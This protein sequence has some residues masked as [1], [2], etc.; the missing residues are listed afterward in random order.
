MSDLE[1]HQDADH[2]LCAY[3]DVYKVLESMPRIDVLGVTI[4]L[5]SKTLDRIAH[6]FPHEALGIVSNY[7]ETLPNIMSEIQQA[8]G[9]SGQIFGASLE[10]STSHINQ[11]LD[12]T[13]LVVFTPSCKRRLLSFMKN[14]KAFLQIT[15]QVSQGSLSAIQELTPSL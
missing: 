4:E 6:L 8:T 1:H 2:I 7:K 11:F 10:Q 15:H 14:E 5:P 9:F 13:D 3:K 12:Q